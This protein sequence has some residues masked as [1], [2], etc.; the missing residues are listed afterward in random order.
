MANIKSDKERELDN[1]ENLLLDAEAYKINLYR[2]LKDLSKQELYDM[3]K[4]K[5]NENKISQSFRTFK[6]ILLDSKL[7]SSNKPDVLLRAKTI[8]LILKN[9]DINEALKEIMDYMDN[10]RLEAFDLKIE[11][12]S[13]KF[14]NKT[15]KEEDHLIKKMNNFNDGLDAPS[16]EMD[17]LSQYIDMKYK[18]K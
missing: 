5:L 12:N 10:K 1:F 3:I 11:I 9:I 15:I 7:I 18:L 13:G 4:G 6:N 14:S 16:R 8:Q 2:R 17:R